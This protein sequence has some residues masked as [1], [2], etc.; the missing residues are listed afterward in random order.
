MYYAS[1]ITCCGQLLILLNRLVPES[2]P[3]VLKKSFD[4]YLKINMYVLFNFETD[5]LFQTEL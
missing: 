1:G 3:T 5:H 4:K 2:T